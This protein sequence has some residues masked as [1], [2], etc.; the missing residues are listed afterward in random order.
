MGSPEIV[1]DYNLI[2]L[3][4]P[5][6]AGMSPSLVREF[7]EKVPMVQNKGLFVYNT[8]GIAEGI[9]NWH[10]IHQLE[11]KGFRSLGYSS[12]I[13]PASDEISMLV[14]KDSRLH[15]RMLSKN[16]DQIKKVD[17]YNKKIIKTLNLLNSAQS[18]NE[19][20]HKKPIKIFGFIVTAI[21]LGL[22]ALIGEIMRKKLHADNKC[23]TCEICIKECPTQN[24]SLKENQI[25]FDNRCI[26]C[27]RCINN[28]PEEA[29]QIGKISIG[30]A[31]WHGP[32]NNYKSLRYKIPKTFK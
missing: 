19:L 12:F 28:C 30:K 24:I 23:T 22:Y 25:V 14:K 4:F 15:R 6:Y 27:L 2:C 32:K 5:V 13:M 20:P 9:A 21:L 1:K 10:I 29:I 16:F 7:I 11:K 18:I 31:R 8:K 26:F 3:G 17:K